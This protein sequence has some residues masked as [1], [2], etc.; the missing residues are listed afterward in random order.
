MGRLAFAFTFASRHFVIL[1]CEPFYKPQL[2]AENTPF[3]A[4]NEGVFVETGV[5]RR[6]HVIFEA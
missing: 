2:L 4:V 5:Y 6:A 3:K 1:A